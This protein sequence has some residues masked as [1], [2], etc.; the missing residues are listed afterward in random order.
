MS[1]LPTTYISNLI[2]ILCESTQCLSSLSCPS[3]LIPRHSFK[4]SLAAQHFLH[5]ANFRGLCFHHLLLHS[6]NMA[7]EAEM[8]LRLSPDLKTVGS[9]W[10]CCAH[11]LPSTPP[12]GL[13]SPRH[14]RL[15][16]LQRLGVWFLPT[17]G[18]AWISHQLSGQGFTGE[19]W[20]QGQNLSQSGSGMW[21]TLEKE[22][23]GDP[24]TDSNVA[25][26]FALGGHNLSGEKTK[27]Q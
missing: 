27:G 26:P 20:P 7:S 18:G 9:P 16:G 25:D 5:V 22:Q 8:V 24:L 4:E 1:A 17:S 23:E 15:T 10:L 11:T 14:T 6:W 19:C 13:A 2:L 21:M 12:P 3:L